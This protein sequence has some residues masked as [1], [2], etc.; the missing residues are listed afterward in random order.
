MIRFSFLLR[1]QRMRFSEGTGFTASA[2]C[3]RLE[4]RGQDGQ[5]EAEQ[6]KHGALTLG[7]S[8]S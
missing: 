8:F 5:D 2:A 3:L 1:I 7:D 6:C 4:W